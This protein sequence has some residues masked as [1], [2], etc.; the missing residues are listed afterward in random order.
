[1]TAF[2]YSRREQNG[3]YFY[4]FANSAFAST[5]LTLLLGPYIVSIA[6]T[7]ADPDGFI[8]LLGVPLDPRS[9]WSYLVAASV[10]VQ[11]IV[12]PLVGAIADSSARKKQLLATFAY[13]GS[14]LTMSLFFVAGSAYLL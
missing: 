2:E 13:A 5:V 6:K 8:R 12:L 1:M 9:W 14:I 7:G 10:M 11:V 3:W 4:D